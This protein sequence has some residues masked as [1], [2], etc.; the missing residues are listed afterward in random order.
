M[1]I[2]IVLAKN[3][4]KFA[5]KSNSSHI[6]SKDS[7]DLQLKPLLYLQKARCVQKDVQA[8]SCSQAVHS[9]PVIN[10]FKHCSNTETALL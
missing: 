3:F 7:P 6:P 1:S 10:Y 8:Q 9:Y 4:F 5:E 2:Y